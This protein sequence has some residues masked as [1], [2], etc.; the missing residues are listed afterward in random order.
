MRY[1][2]TDFGHQTEIKIDGTLDA[3]TAPELRW[4]FDQLVEQQR[5][6]VVLE[7]SGMH[8]IDDS[9]VS[10]IVKLMSSVRAYGGQVRILG[11]HDQPRAIMRLLRLDRAFST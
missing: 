9:G 1:T 10:V 7:V 8:L 5:F 11:L 6:D 2:R 4:V 3:V